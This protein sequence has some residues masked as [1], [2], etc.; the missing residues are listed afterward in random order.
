MNALLDR[1]RR[2]I[3]LSQRKGGEKEALKKDIDLRKSDLELL[4]KQLAQEEKDLDSHWKNRFGKLDERLAR[5]EDLRNQITEAGIALED[6]EQAYTDF[7]SG[8]ITENTLADTIIEGLRQGRIGVT[9]FAAYMNDMLT[10]AVLQSFSA[11]ILGPAI[12]EL[13]QMVAD[14]LVDGILTEE[15]ANAIQKRASEI[16]KDNEEKFRLATQG[17][18]S[19]TADTSLTGAIKGITEETASVI[20]GQMN[21]IRISQATANN[22]LIDSLRNLV[23]IESNTRY[24]RHLESIDS[25]LDALKNNDL[26]AQGL[27]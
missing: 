14:A 21:A 4:K 19:D 25:K 18:N 15:E 1:Q 7:L 23:M 10:E 26:R 8:G 27:N 6:A 11:A 9:D 17:L 20:A 22:I 13:Q 16:A 24:C 3:E 12:T 2:L 5:M